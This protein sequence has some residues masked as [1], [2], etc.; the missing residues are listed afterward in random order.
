MT[1]PTEN[2]VD[3]ATISPTVPSGWT[4]E[5]AMSAWQQMRAELATDE[6]LLHDENAI[7]VS[8]L[9]SDASDP[10]EL[11]PRLI[12]GCAWADRRADEA[13][14]IA[15]EFTARR[16][17]YEA[18]V[19]RLRLIIDQVMAGIPVRRA[20]GKLATAA[21]VAAPPSLLTTDE[22]LIPDEWFRV[23]RVLRK[24]EL[25]RHIQETGEII[26]GVLVS[27]GGETLRLTK[28]K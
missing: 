27:N 17:R 21:I 4:L 15:K 18:R 2:R 5:R 3:D 23:E 25:K 16:E 13:R 9:A 6:E 11:L 19:E 22:Q 28:V 1:E 24:L 10:R 20:A 26:P 7:A 14:A 8:L 12:D